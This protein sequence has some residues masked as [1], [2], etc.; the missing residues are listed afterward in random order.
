MAFPVVRR[1]TRSIGGR[2]SPVVTVRVGDRWALGAVY[3]AGGRSASRAI[4]G[5]M[6]VLRQAGVRV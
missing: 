5:C 3:L 2:T 6:R 4:A 1:E